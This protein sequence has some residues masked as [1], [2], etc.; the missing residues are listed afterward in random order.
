MYIV[1]FLYDQYLPGEKKNI[2]ERPSQGKILI[3]SLV[4]ERTRSQ[5]EPWRGVFPLLREEEDLG[6]QSHDG[7]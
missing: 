7:A 4:Y 1:K 3:S 2:H 6:T 5:E